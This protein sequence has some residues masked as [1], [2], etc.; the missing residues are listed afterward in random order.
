LSSNCFRF[1][2]FLFLFTF[3]SFSSNKVLP[4]AISLSLVCWGAS[5]SHVLKANPAVCCLSVYGQFDWPSN[6]HYPTPP[7]PPHTHT[8]TQVTHVSFPHRRWHRNWSLWKSRSAMCSCSAISVTLLTHCSAASDL[9]VSP[10]YI[11]TCTTDICFN[12]F[13]TVG[14]ATIQSARSSYSINWNVFEDLSIDGYSCFCYNQSRAALPRLIHFTYVPILAYS[15]RSHVSNP[16][17]VLTTGSFSK[18]S[19]SQDVSTT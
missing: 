14:T 16:H 3:T 18:N 12:I 5:L 13:M 9:S 15:T 8:H 1:P 2:P 6:R 4:S 17:T 7:P 10:Q 11:N 19:Y